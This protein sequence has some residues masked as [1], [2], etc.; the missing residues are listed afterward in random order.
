MTQRNPAQI[1]G[2]WQP[3]GSRVVPQL[4]DFPLVEVKV[5]ALAQFAARLEKSRHGVGLLGSWPLA[6]AF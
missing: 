5:E 3:G 6:R 1:G 4:L 2:H